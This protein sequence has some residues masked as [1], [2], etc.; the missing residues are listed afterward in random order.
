MRRAFLIALALCCCVLS[1]AQRSDWQYWETPMQF[2]PIVFDLGAE[3]LGI[4]AEH[5]VVDR[6]V[7]CA[8]GYGSMFILTQ[9]LKSLVR[10]QRPDGS[11]YRSFPSGH[12]AAAMTGAELVR[13]D[14]GWGLGGVFYVG[15]AAVAC[16]RVIH[17]RHWWWDTVAGAGIGVLS[18]WVGRWTADA[19]D[20]GSKIEAKKESN[21][22]V[23]PSIDPLTGAYCANLVWRF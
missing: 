9:G 3:Y 1:R 21:L 17:N 7:A 12:T 6:A 10:E 23:A 16:G 19:L 8:V 13:Q 4:E 18:A 20:L 11:N 2:T 22:A 14:Y 15:G 5:G